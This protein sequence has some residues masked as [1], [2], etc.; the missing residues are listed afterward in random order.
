M[1]VSTF[2][3]IFRTF[4]QIGNSLYSVQIQQNTDQKKH[5]SRRFFFFYDIF[6]LNFDTIYFKKFQHLLLSAPFFT[7]TLDRTA[8]Q[9]VGREGR[10]TDRL[11]MKGMIDGSVNLQIYLLLETALH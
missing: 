3:I 2:S 6:L 11:V 9:R 10:P 5:F 4:L 8:E 7:L 1:L